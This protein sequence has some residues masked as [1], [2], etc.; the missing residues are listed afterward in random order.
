MTDGSVDLTNIRDGE[1][2]RLDGLPFEDE[3]SDWHVNEHFVAS[4]GSASPAPFLERLA[5]K[6]SADVMDAVILQRA[7]ASRDW[8]GFIVESGE[9]E[10]AFRYGSDVEK[11]DPGD[12]EVLATA[13]SRG[14]LDV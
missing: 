8:I 1:F 4:A 12:V 7:D 14:G 11:F 13:D 2:V 10:Q 3:P 6:T 5:G 9:V